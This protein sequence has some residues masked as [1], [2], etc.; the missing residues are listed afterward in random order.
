MNDSLV[1]TI[2]EIFKILNQNAVDILTLPVNLRYSH[3][4]EILAEC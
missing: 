1:W 3:F 2:R 4:V